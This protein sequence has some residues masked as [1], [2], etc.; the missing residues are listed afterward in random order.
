MWR[1]KSKITPVPTVFLFRHYQSINQ[2]SKDSASKG[3]LSAQV[4]ILDFFSVCSE[5]IE[6]MVRATD[7]EFGRGW[8]ILYLETSSNI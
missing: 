1:K 5:L 7:L 4:I 8:A 6:K 2:P 3:I